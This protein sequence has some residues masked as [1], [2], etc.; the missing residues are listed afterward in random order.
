MIVREEADAFVMIEQDHHAV[1]SG[2]LY[3]NLSSRFTI[4]D[5]ATH[6]AIRDAIYHHDIGWIPFDVTPLWDDQN[7]APYSFITLPNTIK[8]V[9][10]KDGI[11]QIEQMNTYAALLCSEH[12][13]RFLQKDQSALCEKFIQTERLRQE[14]IIATYHTFHHDTFLAH[15]ELLQFFDNLSLYICLHK[16]GARKVDTHYFFEMGIQIPEVYGGGILYLTLKDDKIILDKKLFHN[17]VDISLVQ[18]SVSKEIITKV[19]LM[20]AWEHTSRETVMIQVIH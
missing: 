20:H 1:I 9:L 17:P 4:R 10:Y 16:L 7:K 14:S 11:D 18:K 13:V 2:I 5:E 12:Y 6:H 3:D 8:T 19:G 15:Y